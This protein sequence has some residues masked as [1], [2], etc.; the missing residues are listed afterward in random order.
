MPGSDFLLASLAKSAAF[1]YLGLP[2]FEVQY[3][4]LGQLQSCLFTM[5]SDLLRPLLTVLASTTSLLFGVTLNGVQASTL[6]ESLM[7]ASYLIGF[8]DYA[9]AGLNPASNYLSV[10]SSTP[11]WLSLLVSLD[12]L[13][14]ALEVFLIGV[15]CISLN[16]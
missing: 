4:T 10:L 11:S 14:T 5:S 16:R 1:I 15:A 2:Y 3:S 7:L 6:D 9:C 12:P 8:V 13:L